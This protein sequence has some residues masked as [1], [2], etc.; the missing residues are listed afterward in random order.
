LP[1]R[2]GSIVS[3]GVYRRVRVISGRGGRPQYHRTLLKAPRAN[4]GQTLTLEGRVTN[5]LGAARASV[6]VEV[7]ERMNLARA[8]WT[9]VATIH[10]DF[11]GRFT[12]RSPAGPS[13][14]IRFD[15]AGSPTTRA[16]AAEVAVNVKAGITLVPS[17]RRLHNGESVR[18]KGRLRGQPI[19]QSGKL[20]ALQAHTSRGWR[21]FATTR[22]RA[23]DGRWHYAYQFTATEQTAR[24]S[25]RAVVPVESGY[26]YA[27]G[28]SNVRRVLVIGSG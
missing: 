19:P 5:S 9:R 6:P 1:V 18:L 27:A 11:A 13:R 10:S 2:D 24:Y 22:A 17:S 16:A 7:R 14:T 28:V 3:A 25:F 15:Y 26:P 12:F 20:V 4:L 23:T 8:P 21:T